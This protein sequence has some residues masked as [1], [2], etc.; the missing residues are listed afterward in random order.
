MKRTVGLYVA[1]L[2]AAGLLV[3]AADE[4]H[5]YSFYTLL[6]W[7]CCPVFAYSAFAAHGKNRVPWV[8]VFGVLA[9]LYNPIFRVELDRSTWIIVNWLTVGAILIAIGFFWASEIKIVQQAAPKDGEALRRGLTQAEE[10]ELKELKSIGYDQMT[11]AQSSRRNVL[12][13]KREQAEAKASKRHVLIG[14][15]IAALVCFYFGIGAGMRDY[16]R[17]NKATGLAQGKVVELREAEAGE[18]GQYTITVADYKFKVNG[19]D[20]D[21]NTESESMSKGD[22]VQIY[23][24][25]ANPDFNHAEGDGPENGFINLWTFFGIVCLIVAFSEVR[26]QRK[27]TRAAVYDEQA[28]QAAYD[29]YR[30]SMERQGRI[31]PEN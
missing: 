25:P 11:G 26:E 4:R 20:Y 19:V 30:R 12:E 7:I 31:K 1:W 24:N 21:G 14:I 10:A 16:K 9:A 5:P 17:F 6:R 3:F 13:L 18:E 2:V 15:V 23:Y 28:A 29:R 8:W 27:K 22:S